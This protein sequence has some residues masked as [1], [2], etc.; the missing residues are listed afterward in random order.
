MFLRYL[1]I[2]VLLLTSVQL[3]G[4][5]KKIVGDTAYWYRWRL[6]LIQ[7]L[8][9]T[10]F[11]KAEEDFAFRFSRDGYLIEIKGSAGIL[12]GTISNYV[13]WKKRGEKYKGEEMIKINTALSPQKINS[14]YELVKE[15]NILELP[16]DADISGWSD[17]LDGVTYFTEYSTQSAYTIKNYWTPKAQGD[18]PEAQKFLLFIDNI[19]QIAD[20]ERNS[21]ALMQIVPRRGCYHTRGGLIHCFINKNSRFGYRGSTK[22][23]VGATLTLG[24]G[25]IGKRFIDLNFG[26]SYQK[27]DN[28]DHAYVLSAYKGGVFSK[29]EWEKR[30][31]LSY[32]IKVKRLAFLMNNETLSNHQILYGRSFGRKTT[33]RLGGDFFSGA[34]SA[35]GLRAGVSIKLFDWMW[36]YSRASFFKDRIDH[37]VGFA[38][39]IDLDNWFLIRGLNLEVNYEKYFDYQDINFTVSTN[40]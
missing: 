21:K 40:F 4:Q 5:G 23:P 18:L 37:E 10:D 12:S 39:S 25:Y 9:L 2:I 35:V 28:G 20:L 34:S 36:A 6:P 3:F 30:D 38:T 7:E 15:I 31:F 11:E 17:G 29:G 24:V 19:T 14:I 8:G 13:F 32:Q 1:S 27:N 33:I 26:G 16:T 22:L